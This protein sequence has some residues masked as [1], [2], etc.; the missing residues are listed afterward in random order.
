M[1]FEIE[2]E[3][4]STYPLRPITMNNTRPLRITAT[5]GTKLVRAKKVHR[6]KSLYSPIN[7]FTTLRH[8]S[9]TQHNQI[10]LSLIVQYSPLQ[11]PSGR[12]ALIIP[13]MAI[14]SPKL[15]RGR[16]LNNYYVN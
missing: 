11:H 4:P 9:R 7:H 12:R 6:F 3:M 2:L 10:E 1:E 15:A 16:G 8:S 14:R 5:A 13:A